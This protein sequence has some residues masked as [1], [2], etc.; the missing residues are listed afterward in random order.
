MNDPL[1]SSDLLADLKAAILK[2]VERKVNAVEGQ[3]GI[4]MTGQSGTPYNQPGITG[5]TGFE[6]SF[7]TAYDGTSTIVPFQWGVSTW[8]SGDTW[9]GS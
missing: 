7:T 8:G 6:A 1:R 5:V 2:A 4:L 9:S 3:R